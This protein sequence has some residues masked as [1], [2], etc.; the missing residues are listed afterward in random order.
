MPER[1]QSISQPDFVRASDEDRERV[2]TQ[3]RDEAA[4]GRLDTEELGARTAALRARLSGELTELTRDLPVSSGSSPN[5]R[6]GL[7]SSA[8]FGSPPTSSAGRPSH[9]HLGPDRRGLLLACLADPRSR[10]IDARPGWVRTPARSPWRPR[11][12][13]GGAYPDASTP[14]GVA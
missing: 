8:L 13:G 9:R 14:R 7:E 1:G 4:A 12:P 3:L 10:D 11:R 2:I 6:P 5:V